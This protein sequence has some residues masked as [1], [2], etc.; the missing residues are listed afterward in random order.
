MGGVPLCPGTLARMGIARGIAHGLQSV[1]GNEHTLRPAATSSESFG[2]LSWPDSVPGAFADQRWNAKLGRHGSRW[3]CLSHSP[4]ACMC[5]SQST[6]VSVP[7]HARAL[8]HRD[9]MDVQPGAL[10]PGGYKRDVLSCAPRTN[11]LAKS[12]RGQLV[13]KGWRRRVRYFSFFLG[14]DWFKFVSQ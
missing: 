2:I 11:D 3:E 5:Q 12:E 8:L 6:Y 10:S 7:E 13:L 9:E 1:G 4:R 14:T